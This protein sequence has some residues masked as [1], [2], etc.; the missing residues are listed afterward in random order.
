[1]TPKAGGVTASS[2][3]AAEAGA[4]ILRKGGNAV[5]A[6]VATALASCVADPS[7]TGI[8]GYGGHMVVAPINGEP[9]C[10]DFNMWLPTSRPPASWRRTYPNGSPH[11]T[12]VPNVIAGL[13]LALERL[14]SMRWPDVVEPAIRLAASGVEANGTTSRAFKEAEG[15]PFVTECFSFDPTDKPGARR[16]SLPSARADRDVGNVVEARAGVVLRGPDRSQRL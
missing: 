4:Q 10:I 11:V 14:G 5:D 1:M 12:A 8:G 16:V 3:A 2:A 15:A 13:A 9:I 6:A 7:N